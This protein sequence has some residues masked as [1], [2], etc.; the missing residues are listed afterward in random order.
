MRKPRRILVAIKNPGSRAQPALRKAAQLALALRAQ[1]EIFHAISEP[2]Y[3]DAFLLEGMTLEQT[4]KQW[5]DR[6]VKKLQKHADG[7]RAEGLEVDVACEWDFPA[8]EAIIRRAA[9]TD[10]DLI[11]AERHATRHVLPWLLRFNDWELLRR[12]P[13]PVLLV[14]SGAAWDKPAVLA[15]I[16]PGHAYAKPA[17]LDAAILDLGGQVAAAL[18]GKLHAV[19]AFVPTLL[20]VRHLDLDDPN[21]PATIEARAAQHARAGFDRALAGADVPAPRRHLVARHPVDAIPET[22]KAVGAGVVVMGA[23]SRSGLKRLTVGDTAEQIL[24]S[25]AR[26]VLIVKPSHFAARVPP[27][28]RGVQLIASPGIV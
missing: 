9:R 5:R 21:L 1:V 11:V 18:G 28:K 3:L 15:A 27:R 7:L 19:H 24:D 6:L 13:V 12:S 26:D 10:A 20:D 16:D 17:K 23:V 25:L 4:Q 14:K 8:Y 22:A 2:V